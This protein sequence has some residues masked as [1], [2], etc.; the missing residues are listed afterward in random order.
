MSSDY[1]TW[2]VIYG[3]MRS[4]Q[5]IV[6]DIGNQHC[7]LTT[8]QGHLYDLAASRYPR[9]KNAESFMGIFYILV[10]LKCSQLR[11]C[12]SQMLTSGNELLG[13]N[14]IQWRRGNLKFKGD[15]DEISNEQEEEKMKKNNDNN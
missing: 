3:S 13:Q 10:C 9:E 15:D 8:C 4:R 12:T 2:A 7:R 1:L 11:F 5:T 14:F 6:L